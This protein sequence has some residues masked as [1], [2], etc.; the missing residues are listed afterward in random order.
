MCLEQL[1]DELRFPVVE[2]DTNVAAGTLTRALAEVLVRLRHASVGHSTEHWRLGRRLNLVKVDDP[3]SRTLI[4]SPEP[5]QLEEEE[6]EK[7]ITYLEHFQ[8]C[9]FLPLPVVCYTFCAT[10]GLRLWQI[11]HG[12]DILITTAVYWCRL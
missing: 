5:E 12:V 11:L 10:V 4:M 2:R 8:C 6:E 9:F 1:T 3:R 7:W